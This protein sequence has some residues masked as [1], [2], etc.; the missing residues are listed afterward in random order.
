MENPRLDGRKA[1]SKTSEADSKTSKRPSTEVIKKPAGP[2]GIASPEASSLH[3]NVKTKDKS[4]L[5]HSNGIKTK[6]QYVPNF[7]ILTKMGNSPNGHE[8]DSP[9]LNGM[10]KAHFD[11]VEEFNNKKYN[12]SA[13][14]GPTEE[15]K[16]KAKK[17]IDSLVRARLNLKERKELAYKHL[18]AKYE[19]GNIRAD[20]QLASKGL[21]RNGVNSLEVRTIM[22]AGRTAPF[23]G[24]MQKFEDFDGNLTTKESANSELFKKGLPGSF[25]GEQIIE[26]MGRE[27]G[28]P[29]GHAASWRQ[30]LLDAE[31]IKLFEE[32]S[33]LVK[34]RPY[35][36][37][38]IKYTKLKGDIFSLVTANFEPYARSAAKIYNIY[39][40]IDNFYAVKADDIGS[41]DKLAVVWKS[42]CD[43]IDRA[44]ACSG[45]SLGDYTMVEDN[46]YKLYPIV[47][48]YSAPKGSPLAEKLKEKMA[49]TPGFPPVF[50]FENGIDRL[51]TDF[52]I[53]QTAFKYF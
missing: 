43:N 26:R 32:A 51:K 9:L 33:K 30:A 4:V 6:D 53:R 18:V 45:D 31:G 5:P 49:N 17:L 16:I 38:Y 47:A 8:E 2:N 34:L 50:E 42:A 35:M 3:L 27:E 22:A 37:Q 24:Q 19:Y 39:D 44:S 21:H 13:E 15:E 11:A 29:L 14:R 28:F 20:K 25:L 36:E 23:E 7:I 1:Y 41:T 40:Y 46:G 48:Y 52:K 10:H 12:G